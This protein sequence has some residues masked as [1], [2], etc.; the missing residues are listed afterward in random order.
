MLVKK[1]IYITKRTKVRVGSF[2]FNL[3]QHHCRF[4]LSSCLSEVRVRFTPCVIIGFRFLRAF[5][6]LYCSV[7]FPIRSSRPS[8]RWSVKYKIHDSS[9]C[10]FHLLV[11]LF[12]SLFKVTIRKGQRGATCFEFELRIVR[13]ED[14]G[15][16]T[17]PPSERRLFYHL[18][19]LYVCGGAHWRSSLVD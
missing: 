16:P 6:C 10:K 9:K 1:Y 15:L 7:T 14:A 19:F 11:F 17:W 8:N 13:C 5:K 3:Q 18:F 4:F 12:Y 2:D